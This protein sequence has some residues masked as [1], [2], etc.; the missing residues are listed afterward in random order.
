MKMADRLGM[1]GAV[2]CGLHC[3]AITLLIM[4]APLLTWMDTGDE[5]HAYLA[6]FAILPVLAGLLPGYLVHR[7]Q[8]VIVWGLAGLLC[9][10]VAV[11]LIGPVYG[12]L[13]ETLVTMCGA[14]LLFFAHFKNH[15]CRLLCMSLPES[16]L[17]ID[18]RK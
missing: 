12:E 4:V 15:R 10:G 11:W 3:I 6:L 18:K 14:V 1:L 17:A 16:G 5:V 8:E 9:L 2:L 7:R 13:A